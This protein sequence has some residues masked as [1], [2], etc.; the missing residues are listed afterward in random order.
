MTSNPANDA[1][2]QKLTETFSAQH[3]E[4]IDDSWMHAGHAGSGGGSHLTVVVVSDQFEGKMGLDR[5]R[6]VQKAL[7]EEMQTSIHALI[8]KPF[9][10]TEFE[11][12]KAKA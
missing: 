8:I 10:P 11:A 9:T 4:V 12:E 6:A 1:I 3:V 2:Q 5:H 7:K